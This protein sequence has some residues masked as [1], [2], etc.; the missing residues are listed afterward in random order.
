MD[1]KRA[2]SLPHVVALTPEEAANALARD[3]ENAAIVA[4][5]CRALRQRAD[6]YGFAIQRLVIIAPSPSALEAQRA[7]ALLQTRI[8]QYCPAL[9]PGPPGRIVAKN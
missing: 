4:W 5:V 1:R 7:I 2:Q 8:G 6:S 9:P 3:N